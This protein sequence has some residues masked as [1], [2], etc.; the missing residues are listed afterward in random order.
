MFRRWTDL[1]IVGI[2]EGG[3]DPARVDAVEISAQVARL[4]EEVDVLEEG[5]GTGVDGAGGEED[6]DTDFK[7]E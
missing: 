2:D 6:Q 3:V 5:P 7:F 1:Q 4:L